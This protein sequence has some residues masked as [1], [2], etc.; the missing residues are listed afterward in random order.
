MD[1]KVSKKELALEL[2]VSRSMLYYEHKRP[3]K[4]ERLRVAIEAVM[5]KNPG[6]GHR[7][8]ADGLK[9][10]RKR[11]LRVMKLYGLKPARRC[12]SVRK[13]DD[14]GNP[15]V[16]FPDITRS[17]C[18]IA[19]NVLWI[20]D[21]TFIPYKGNFIYLATIL[22]RFTAEVLGASIMVRHTTELPLTAL[23]TALA[24]SEMAP[25]WCHSDQ[26]SE[27][28]SDAF[29]SELA[30]HNI[31]VSMSPKA[32]PWRN[33]AQESFF[34]RF[35][36]EFGDPERFGNIAELMEA[37]YAF[38]AYYNQERI[39]TRFRMSPAQFKAAWLQK[40]KLLTTSPQVMSLPPGPPPDDNCYTFATEDHLTDTFS[41]TNNL[42][43][44]EEL[45]SEE[46]GT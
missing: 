13:P 5:I 35:K 4:D 39:H 10:N 20:S 28:N 32:S 7:R 37:I 19:P 41:T 16:N 3:V 45:M 25:D 38:I 8:V 21:F 17:F 1:K 44:F 26:G 23:R 15:A 11:V 29:L 2:G 46:R 34:G 27:Y 43:C 30:K 24:H 33:G 42:I 22:D 40:H 14:I 36:V 9:V 12:Y 6:Y 31:Q 18:P